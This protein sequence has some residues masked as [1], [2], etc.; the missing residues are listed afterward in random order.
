MDEMKE[1]ESLTKRMTSMEWKVRQQSYTDATT[2]LR[3]MQG[4][5]GSVIAE[6]YP[7][8]EGAANDSNASA[9][10]CAMEMIE[11]WAG[12]AP[13]DMVSSVAELVATAAVSRGL[14][15]RPASVVKAH[16]MLNALMTIDAATFPV[17]GALLEGTGL[18]KPKVPPECLKCLTAAYR[19]FGAGAMPNK[20]VL[21]KLASLLEDKRKETRAAAL[22][23]AK[24]LCRWVSLAT[25]LSALG[26]VRDC[27]K[28]ELEARCSAT[29]ST[30][31]RPA[32]GTRA[33]QL[34]RRDDL[35]QRKAGG[36]GFTEGR[37][38]GGFGSIAIH[39]RG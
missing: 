33:A 32:V 36:Y 24:E 18:K 8:L 21:A 29:Q 15:G 35:L 14:A 25:V 13:S 22:D 5:N 19:D 16:V 3:T 1:G 28:K 11:A 37:R 30:L 17:V 26:G 31:P 2:L 4:N 34:F 23:L 6:L 38:R 27:T 7:M 39:R 9:N 10:D 12:I 20:E